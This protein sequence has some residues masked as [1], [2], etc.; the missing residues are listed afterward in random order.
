MS[1]TSPIVVKLGGST[2]GSHD[3]SLQDLAS[4]H[5]QGRPLVVV[6]GGGA[7]ISQWLEVHGVEARFVR[8][9]RATDEWTL[10]VVVATLAGLTNKRLVAEL[11]ALG[12]RALGLCGADGA[13]LRARRYDPKLGFVGEIVAVDGAALRALVEAGF[14]PVLAPIG[15]EVEGDMPRPQLLNINADTAAGEVAR[16]LAAPHLIL[17]TDV[18]GVLDR[19]GHPLPCL[20]AGEAGELIRAGTAGG[21]MIPKLEAA[22]RAVELGGRAVI[23]DGREEHALRRALAGEAPGTVIGP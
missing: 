21:G 3:T 19:D 17:L 8:G 11:A 2:L 5:R 14:L 20:T 15:L 23:V 4:L 18:P 16:A 7:T 22:L 6:H 10:E 12:A 13:L 1:S 9:L